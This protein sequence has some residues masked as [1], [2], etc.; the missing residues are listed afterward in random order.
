M[1][2]SASNTS[3]W[4]FV[5]LLGVLSLSLAVA[6]VLRRRIPLI[7]RTMIPTAV[8]AGFLLLIVRETGLVQHGPGFL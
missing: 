3:L 7:R 2:Y 4:S 1:D 8:L 5:L 6:V